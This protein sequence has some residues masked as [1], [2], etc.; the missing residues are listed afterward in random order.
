MELREFTEYLVKSIVSNPDKVR[1]SEFKFEDGLV[2]E[3]L[4]SDTDRSSVIG[5][6]G[7]MANYIRVLVQAKAYI[8]KLGKVKINIDSI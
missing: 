6:G 5:K 8:M 7:K 1:V 2:L 4:V 3:V